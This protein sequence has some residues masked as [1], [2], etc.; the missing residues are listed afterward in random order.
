[1]G[2]EIWKSKL[3]ILQGVEMGMAALGGFFSG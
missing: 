1:M 2:G 3:K